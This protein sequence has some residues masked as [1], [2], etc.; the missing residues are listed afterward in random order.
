[1]PVSE[2]SVTRVYQHNIIR[3]CST[4]SFKIQFFENR[5]QSQKRIYAAALNFLLYFTR[6]RTK[7]HLFQS[8]NKKC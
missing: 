4:N 3:D 1:M 5:F 8:N 6:K 7:N 2:A